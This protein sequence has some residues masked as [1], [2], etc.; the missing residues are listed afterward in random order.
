M[1]YA[2]GAFTLNTVSCDG[3]SLNP[4]YNGIC[5][6]R[7]KDARADA[8]GTVLI[9]IIMEYALGEPFEPYPV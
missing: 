5:S 6:R 1:E 2:L 9:L 7:C 4:Y 8:K 3:Q